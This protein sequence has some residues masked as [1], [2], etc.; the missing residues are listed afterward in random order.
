M[1][2]VVIL[3]FVKSRDPQWFERSF[4]LRAHILQVSR[5]IIRER[6]FFGHGLG[7]FTQTFPEYE[8]VYA[9]ERLVGDLGRWR[10]FPRG[11]SSHNWFLRLTIEGGL[12]SLLTFLGLI[13]WV[14][15][16]RWYSLRSP[17]PPSQEE[18]YPRP[19]VRRSVR[20][21]LAAALVGFVVQAL[22]EE[23]FAYS[24]IVVIF[25]ALVAVGVNLDR[26]ARGFEE[27]STQRA[28]ADRV[29]GGRAV[30]AGKRPSAL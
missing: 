16:T 21:A 29:P 25:W 7:L 6:P 28:E 3:S 20:V 10:A 18:G 15:A 26:S 1:G 12:A 8:Q 23:I 24:K 30:D 27:G 4:A 11:I 22:T 17:P 19:L 2:V 5:Q 14:M 9:R 13:G